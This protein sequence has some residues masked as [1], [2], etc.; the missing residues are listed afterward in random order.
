MFT[1]IIATH[2]RPLLLR[3]TLQSLLAQ[4]YQEF[5]V[6]I[7]SDTSSYFP[8]Y[9]ELKQ[10]Q[11]R[12]TFV[13]RSGNPG[14]SESRNMGL[15]LA[16][17]EYIIFLDDDDT[18][19]PAHLQSVADRIGSAKP[20]LLYTDLTAKDENREKTPPEPLATTPINLGEID[21]ETIYIRNR[22]PNNCLIFRRDVV[23]GLRF[24]TGMDMFEDWDFLLRCLS[25]RMLTY[26]PV[27]SVNVHR[28]SGDGEQN[29]HRGR[30]DGRKTINYLMAMYKLHPAPNESIRSRRKVM[31]ANYGL[32]F[33]LAAF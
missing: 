33:P 13:I 2:D 25:G 10:L 18:F 27:N 29:M 24:D 20:E 8:P 16:Q 19:E 6:I 32:D 15:A 14:P 11:G 17:S 12:Y 7:V 9:E 31:F 23:A 26:I 1:I 3:R 22:I 21:P 5:K 28:C 4:T 30:V